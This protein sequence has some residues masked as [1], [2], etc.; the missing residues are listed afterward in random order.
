VSNSTHLDG[1]AIDFWVDPLSSIEVFRLFDRTWDGGLGYYANGISH[2]DIG[3]NR[4]W[5]L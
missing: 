3:S 2:V 4:R 5:Q 1:G